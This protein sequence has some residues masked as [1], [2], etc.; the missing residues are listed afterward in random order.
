[1]FPVTVT[2]DYQLREYLS[3]VWDFAQYVG[4]AR[5]HRDIV[6]PLPKQEKGVGAFTKA[7]LAIVA[8]PAFF[9][10][11]FR[12]GRCEF[13]FTELGITRKSKA[14][15]VQATWQDIHYIYPLSQAFLIAKAVGAMPVPYRCFSSDQRELL[16]GLFTQLNAVRDMASRET[17]NSSFLPAS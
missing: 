4:K 14:R 8:T 12:V 5:R 7:G 2:V 13:T 15:T 17:P 16:E 3:V 9:Y 1:M 6:H 11:V 10:K